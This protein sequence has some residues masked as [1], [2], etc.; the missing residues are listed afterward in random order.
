M[1]EGL[2]KRDSCGISF[3]RRDRHAFS[4]T[5]PIW[6]AIGKSVRMLWESGIRLAALALSLLFVLLGGIAS[7]TCARIF[8]WRL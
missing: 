5:F 4:R 1:I 7:S 6:T 3:Y 8:F 2:R